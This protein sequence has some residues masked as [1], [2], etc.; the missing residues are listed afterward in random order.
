MR[1][2][3]SQKYA[4]HEDFLR[5]IGAYMALEKLIGEFNEKDIY[6]NEYG[7]PLIKGKPFVNYAHSGRYAIASMHDK[8]VGVD[9]E[10]IKESNLKLAS[11]VFTKEEQDYINEQDSANRFHLLWCKKESIMKLVGKGLS[12]PFNKIEIIDENTIQVDSKKYSNKSFIYNNEY[13]ISI[14]WEE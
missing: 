12:L 2:E 6:F 10:L 5:S 4:F 9:V 1:Y 13:A 14:S 8:P 3:K 11:K 7:K